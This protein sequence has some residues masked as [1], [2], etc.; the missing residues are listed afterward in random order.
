LL[1]SAA[2]RAGDRDVLLALAAF[3]REAG[4]PQPLCDISRD[5]RRSILMTQPSPVW[6]AHASQ[7]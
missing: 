4:I 3:K 5:S 1:E 2:Q 7:A 6:R